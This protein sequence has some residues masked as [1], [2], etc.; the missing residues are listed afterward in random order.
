[1]W[2]N[3]LF[4]HPELSLVT[5]DVGRGLGENRSSYH[6]TKLVEIL[7]PYDEKQL[8]YCLERLA[9]GDSRGAAGVISNASRA[10]SLLPDTHLLAGAFA[11]AQGRL[12]DALGALEQCGRESPDCGEAIRRI[13]PGL[14]ILV[15]ITPTVLIPVH[16][17]EYGAGLMLAVAHWA[18]GQPGAALE[19]VRDLISRHGMRDELRLMGG[20]LLVQRGEVDRA[21]KAMRG[22]H[23]EEEDAVALDHALILAYALSLQEQ[24]REAA[25][26]L[27]KAVRSIRNVN[28]HLQARCKLLL[29]ELYDRCEMPFEALAVSSEVPADVM[30]PAVARSQ[31]QREERWLTEA[32]HM[33]GA[34]L[35][36]MARANPYMMY[37]PDASEF[38]DEKRVSKLDIHRDPVAALKPREMSW[39]RRKVDEHRISEYK[40]AVAR[41]ESVPSPHGDRLSV[42]GRQ[43][44]QRV[45]QAEQWWPGRSQFL[46]AALMGSTG[47]QAEGVTGHVLFDFCSAHEGSLKLLEGEHRARL[48]CGFGGAVF[49]AALVMLILRLAVY[50]GA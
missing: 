45:K 49:V 30:P 50:G 4:S 21:I 13:Y 10:G 32:L 40:S 7:M 24:Y 11:L 3:W 2:D 27:T 39:L 31:Q 23:P 48:V 42:E 22:A 16:P 14:R 35:E 44:R 37:I 8:L 9:G 34:E 20:Y 15:R 5:L 17:N 33:G 38:T 43:F 46:S 26:L 36:R 1:M 19:E 47:L 12:D 28:P 25:M 29:A 41:G 18:S 6:V